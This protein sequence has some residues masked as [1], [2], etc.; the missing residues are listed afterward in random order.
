M[1]YITGFMEVMS[2]PP[3]VT[4]YEFIKGLTGVLLN[5]IV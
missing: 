4:E 3:S 1:V 5:S 2:V